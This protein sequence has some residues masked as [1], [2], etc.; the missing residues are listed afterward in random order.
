[1]Y[2]EVMPINRKLKKF[3]VARGGVGG[4]GTCTHYSHEWPCS[5]PSSEEPCGWVVG[6]RGALL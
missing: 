6:D 3:C 5:L 4:G 1:M 2:G